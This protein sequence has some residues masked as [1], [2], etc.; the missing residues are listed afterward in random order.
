[1]TM[2]PTQDGPTMSKAFVEELALGCDK[3]R[4]DRLAVA[5]MV[6]KA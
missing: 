1:M 6:N 5:E 4:C 3:L 2:S